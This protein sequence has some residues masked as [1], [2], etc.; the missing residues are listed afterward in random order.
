MYIDV[1]YQTNSQ[2]IY[3]LSSKYSEITPDLTCSLSG[4]TSIAYSI[5]NYN[6]ANA[7]SWVQIDAGSGLLKINAPVVSTDTQYSFYMN[8]VVSGS[9]IQKVITITVINC[10]VSNWQSCV[11]TSGSTCMTCNSSY[12]LLSGNC[13]LQSISNS[14]SSTTQTPESLSKSVNV[15]T[16]SAAGIVLSTRAL[17]GSSYSWFWL[18]VNQLQLLFFLLLTGVYFP[19]EVIEVIVGS[20]FYFFSFEALKINKEYLSKLLWEW[21]STNQ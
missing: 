12:T 9:T 13:I 1:L 2:P 18:M 17:A 10:V 16:I 3:A 6:G 21:L 20:K 14:E 7:P 19:N 4:S 15:I 11:S 5:A 8:S